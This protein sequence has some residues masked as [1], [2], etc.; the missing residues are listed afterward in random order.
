MKWATIWGCTTHLKED[1]KMMTAWLTEIKF[2]IHRQISL[3]LIFP[4]R[5]A[6]N[7]CS[8][9]INSGFSS[10][11]DDMIWN[12]MDYSALA[13]Y[14]GFTAD[15][16][17]RMHW[18]IDQV[19][20][21]LLN[22]N[23]CMD[24]CT[25]LTD[26]DI[27]GPADEIDVGTSFTFNQISSGGTSYVWSVNGVPLGT[28]PSFNYT[29]NQI[30]TFEI[31]LEVFNADPNCYKGAS[32][33]V[34]VICPVS[35]QYAYS[36]QSDLTITLQS[37]ALGNPT[38]LIWEST[39]N[40]I[41]TQIG[42]NTA[43][44]TY[45]ISQSGWTTICLTVAPSGGLCRDTFCQNIFIPDT[46]S[47]QQDH[48][49]YYQNANSNSFSKNRYHLEE[50]AFY[51][52]G[53]EWSNNKHFATLTKVDNCGEVV[54]SKSYFEDAG[55]AYLS[56]VL[57]M[58]D[59]HL[60]ACGGHSPTSNNMDEVSNFFM[61]I[62][63]ATGTLIWMKEYAY[64]DRLANVLITPS[65]NDPAGESYYISH[66]IHKGNFA[67]DG[68]L[69]KI[70]QNGTV[71]WN[72]R[73]VI[74]GSDFE[75]A[76]IKPL[77]LGKLALFGQT[78]TPYRAH[79][80]ILGPDGSIEKTAYYTGPGIITC[81]FRSGE[82]CADG[83][84]LVHGFMNMQKNGSPDK[85]WFIA[86]LTKDLNLLWLKQY[87]TPWQ[88]DGG[89]SIQ[90]LDGNVVFLTD[91]EAGAFR[92][93]GYILSDQDGQIVEVRTLDA[94]WLKTQ[95]PSPLIKVTP[96]QTLSDHIAFGLDQ[97][98]LSNS[99]GLLFVTKTG[100]DHCFL[101]GNIIPLKPG[102]LSKVSMNLTINPITYQ[103][104][105]FSQ[106]SNRNL[107]RTIICGPDPCVEDCVNGQDD[108][109][110]G[111]IDCFDP[112]CPCIAECTS[113][114]YQHCTA[115][116]QTHPTCLDYSIE[117]RWE[118]TI[119]ADAPPSVLVG[120]L[121]GTGKPTIVATRPGQ[122][123][124][125]ILDGL[126]GTLI[127]SISTPAVISMG[128]IPVM[129]D[130]DHDGT[131]ELF[132]ID[133]SNHL[134]SFEH[135]G[136]IRFISSNTVGSGGT[137]GQTTIQLS[138]L[139]QD[140]TPEVCI[141]SK[142]YHALTG[143]LLFSGGPT[144]S[145][146]SHPEVG[147]D[148]Y[149][150]IAIT[151]AV[152]SE[153]CNA[154]TGLELVCGNQLFGID[155]DLQM[156]TMI[157]EANGMLKDGYTSIAD[158][159][160]DGDVDGVVVTHAN[161][162]E[163]CYGWDLQT[164]QV[165]G[166]Y[167][168]PTNGFGASRVAIGDIDGD[169]S[170]DLVFLALPNLIALDN[171]FNLKWQSPISNFTSLSPPVLFD[172]CNSGINQIIIQNADSLFIIDGTNGLPLSSFATNTPLSYTTPVIADCNLDG[173]AEII[174][175]RKKSTNEFSVV[176]LSSGSASWAGTRSVWNQAAF[177]NT[178]IEDNLD[179][180]RT[181]QP[182]Y[183][184][185]SSPSLNTF[186][187]AVSIAPTASPDASITVQSIQCL[188]DSMLVQFQYCNIGHANMPTSI[189]I[190]VY[191]GNASLASA[192]LVGEY[193]IDASLQIDSCRIITLKMPK[194]NDGLYSIVVNTNAQQLP[195][196]VFDPPNFTPNIRECNY[197]NNVDTFHIQFAS[198]LLD[199][200]PDTVICAFEAY[201]IQATAGFEAYH[202]FN[203][204]DE[205]S[206]TI[207]QPG[208]IWVEATDACGIIQRDSI[209][210]TL[211]QSPDLLDLRDTTLCESSVFEMSLP[212]YS[213]YQ[214]IFNDSILLSESDVVQL[215]PV[216]EG[217]LIVIVQHLEG[218]VVT[219]SL[220]IH[221]VPTVR[222]QKDLSI[223][224]GDIIMIDSILVTQ[225]DTIE[226]KHLSQA[227]CD[228]I[229]QFVISVLPDIV[230]DLEVQHACSGEYGDVTWSVL[231]GTPPFLENWTDLNHNPID[232]AFLIPGEYN[233]QITDGNGCTT[234][235][236]VHIET[237]IPPDFVLNLTPISCYGLNDGHIDLTLINEEDY[238]VSLNGIAI[239]PG[240]I[241]GS[242]G[243]GAYILAIQDTLDCVYLDTIHLDEPAPISI[244]LPPDTTLR[245]GESLAIAP[246]GSTLLGTY[247]WIPEAIL[248]CHDCRQ[249][250]A[251][252]TEDSW[253]KVSYTDSMGCVAID[254][255]YIQIYL[256]IKS[257][258]PNSFSPNNDGINDL[259][260]PF[261]PS[262]VESIQH[263]EIYDRW[264]ELIHSQVNL[265]PQDPALGWDG[266]FRHQIMDP[267]LFVYKIDLTLINSSRL[268]FSGE[269]NLI[270]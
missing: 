257:F 118:T 45:P 266:T 181:I 179:I 186:L 160:L 167:S 225:Q 22:T 134:V 125:A 84:F 248:N 165:L 104:G 242:L 95:S 17:N 231:S 50:N 243:P 220:N 234:S 117:K 239:E 237:P 89:E 251:T 32:I 9:D 109:H 103:W 123:S 111:L 223:C 81:S 197:Q 149:N 187:T 62:N 241:P 200:G 87:D 85:D 29:F 8:T 61:K 27:I 264:G 175:S 166:S 65:L 161:G 267:G 52:S 66:W 119:Q 153:S 94:P 232:P 93:P 157:R 228:S 140:G 201:T 207:D 12:F 49:S 245:L 190:S 43:T 97:R 116:C 163:W 121:Y 215:D 154:C 135:T 14:V 141:G 164:N 6:V 96:T 210:V 250:I 159:D 114:Y 36:V 193:R 261:F 56:D 212:G 217:L 195:P 68:G 238:N 108:N 233:I 100:H 40:S 172:F 30:G 229:T 33:Q 206:F 171:N 42:I 19:R 150:G 227:G 249:V 259:F 270:R 151:E 76:A 91:F 183:L 18:F 41:T 142:I 48:A 5:G 130:V 203:G 126:T 254:S 214:W 177:H 240:H 213:G 191:E 82:L 59:G 131:A 73:Y 221:V 196:Y 86:K 39:Q 235:R 24:P 51:C 226:T 146:G 20:S 124:I 127:T 112:D 46:S 78:G 185:K 253:V 4:V 138:D 170:P 246:L 74:P 147:Q 236:L 88:M 180:L 263:F 162:Q 98:F 26:V 133:E 7:T 54:W 258:I 136:D 132:I 110:N 144:F 156:L 77:P 47:L 176:A 268:T 16:S 260:Q 178:H 189:P 169:L 139:D 143:E 202:W 55:Y 58:E 211:I 63:A 122:S 11:E 188:G 90:T 269:L 64:S 230:F 10:D 115:D 173:Q 198:P 247:L 70:D 102:S 262:S 113:H 252:P 60:I 199:I 152:P 80:V 208:T 72:S 205:Q 34:Q 75:I 158:I 37:L 194:Q 265:H 256:N 255:M 105:S 99:K 148:I 71:L 28:T 23:L 224:P 92:Y 31:T 184:V 209:T 38:E 218:C 101:S 69:I 192:N 219:D 15:Q 3:L 83:S 128:S 13:C 1:A 216:M 244:S 222:I 168:F 21:S 67:D 129:G 53:S 174:T 35:S 2:A 44:L 182:H 107:N 79:A 25:S 145:S 155:P 120:D 57:I 204:W 137:T 106:A